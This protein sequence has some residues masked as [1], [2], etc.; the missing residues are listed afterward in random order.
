M[1]YTVTHLLEG[2]SNGSYLVLV[3]SALECGEHGSVDPLVQVPQ[4]IL[5]RLL[6]HGPHTLPVEDHTCSR[7]TPKPFRICILPR[8]LRKEINSTL[9]H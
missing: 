3:R 5:T 4:D 6:V 8:V 1:L 9:I 7:G 2:H